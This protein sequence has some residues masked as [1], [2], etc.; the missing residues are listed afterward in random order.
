MLCFLSCHMVVTPPALSP[1]LSSAA[2]TGVLWGFPYLLP[3]EAVDLAY[4][5]LIFSSLLGL[6][7]SQKRNAFPGNRSRSAQA[8]H[9]PRSA[10]LC[11]EWLAARPMWPLPFT[12]LCLPGCTRPRADTCPAV[13]LGV[14]RGGCAITSLPP[15]K[16][17]PMGGTHMEGRC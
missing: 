16:L 15:Q 7:K 1:L 4:Q 10:C 11:D 8:Y 2:S 6:S 5:S 3:V 14:G 9:A 13:L 12:P 17:Q